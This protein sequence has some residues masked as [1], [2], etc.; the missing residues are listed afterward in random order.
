MPKIAKVKKIKSISQLKSLADKLCSEYIRR[1]YANWKGEVKCFTCDKMLQWKQ[2]Q[3]GHYISRVY[4]NTRYY[5]PNLRPQCYSCNI[6][7]HG[8]MDEFAIRLERETP[9]ILKE[10]NNWKHRPT[11]GNT[12]EDLQLIIEEYK[13]KIKKL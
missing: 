1:K 12:R 3:N 13:T 6:M 5:E 4:S 9:G 2:I 10:L 8:A 7:K 11:S